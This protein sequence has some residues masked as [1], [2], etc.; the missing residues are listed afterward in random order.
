MYPDAKVAHLVR[1][2]AG[3]ISCL[4]LLLTA[5]C[6]TRLVSPDGGALDPGQAVT[7]EKVVAVAK[8]LVGAPYRYGGT[9]PSGFDCSGLVQYAYREAGF[10]LPRS[11]GEQLRYAQSVSVTHLRPGDLL[12][13]RIS[14]RKVSHVAIYS[15]Q[16]RF[17]HAPSSGRRVSYGE[18]DHPFWKKRL[19]SAGRL[20]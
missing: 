6:S 1:R 10:T 15:G 3:T 5:S 14:K 13:F 20:H 7:G 9:T 18:L 16:G 17:I 19:V 8:T 4:A 12:F 2:I 11:T